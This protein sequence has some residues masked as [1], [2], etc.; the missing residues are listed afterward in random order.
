MGPLWNTL[1]P[2][3]ASLNSRPS[4]ST[5]IAAYTACLEHNSAS[6]ET[7]EDEIIGL[8]ASITQW[9]EQPTRTRSKCFCHS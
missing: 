6:T 9:T 7:V 4:R 2:L 5:R 8:E 3:S 1:L